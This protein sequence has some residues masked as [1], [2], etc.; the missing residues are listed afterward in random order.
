MPPRM[1][2]PEEP[3]RALD[4]LMADDTLRGSYLLQFAG[5]PGAPML[6]ED[7]A[8]RFLLWFAVEGRHKYQQIFFSPEYLAFLAAPAP[9]FVTRLAAQVHASRKQQPILSDDDIE[10]FHAW[11]Y[12]VG[13]RELRPD[14]VSRGR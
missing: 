13:V 14:A 2:R 4:V 11:Y 6:D 1:V 9:P 3:V 8:A 7:I 5:N 12:V 10:A